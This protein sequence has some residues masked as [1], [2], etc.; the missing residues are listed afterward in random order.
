[1]DYL[2]RN[3][4]SARWN[5]HSVSTYLYCVWSDL[6]REFNRPTQKIFQQGLILSV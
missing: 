1:M 2:H 6:F 5:L 4:H 3:L